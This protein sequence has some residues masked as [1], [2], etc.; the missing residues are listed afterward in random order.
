MK[1][2]IASYNWHGSWGAFQ[3][4]EA[5]VVGETKEVALG[6]ILEEFPNTDA[7]IWAIN[8]ID[9]NTAKAHYISQRSS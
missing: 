7:S 6:L 3:E 8:E 1:V 5:V 9:T 2:W 4:Y